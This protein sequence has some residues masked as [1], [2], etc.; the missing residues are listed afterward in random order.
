MRVLITGATGFV[1]QRVV[2]QLLAEGHQVVVLSRNVAKGALRL[3]SKCEYF[4][5]IDTKSLPPLEAF[6]GVDGVVNLMGEGIAER[7]WSE[8]QK[9]IIHDSRIISTRNLIEAIGKLSQKPKV[10]V[11]ASAVGIYGNRGD[12]EITEASPVGEDFLA[13]ICKEWEA[14]AFKAREHGL[15]VSVIRTGVVLGRGGGALKK[16]L[17]VFKIG[18]GG[19]LGS[20]EQ[21]MSWIHVDDLASMYVE[22]LKNSSIEGVYNGTAPY[23]AK[24]K[25]FTYALGKALHRR[26]FMP[27]PA[28]GV[29]LIFGE[30]SQVLLEGQKVLPV[31]FKMNNFRYKYPTLEMALKETAY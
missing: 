30:M 23:P 13:Q 24:N 7:R 17:P 10:F 20:G 3:G 15:R 21:F 5:W 12:E 19:P 9:K 4:Q 25:E 22:A 1:G 18:A 11:S 31:N 6:K 28:F 2:K 16:M 26:A 29:K 27:V 14:E 8:E